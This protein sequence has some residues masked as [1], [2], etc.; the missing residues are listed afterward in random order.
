MPRAEATVNDHGKSVRYEGVP[1]SEILKKAGAPMG[2][3]LHGKALASYVLAEG[4]DGYQVLYSMA[5]LDPALT[6]AKVLLADRMD[7]KPLPDS[8]GPFRLIA[9]EDKKLP[10]SVRMLE[11]LELVRLQP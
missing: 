6:Q 11:K 1:V 4:R 9:P 8:V 2:D 7:G 10:R 3:D 5:E